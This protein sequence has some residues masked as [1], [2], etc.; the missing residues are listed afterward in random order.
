VLPAPAAGLSRISLVV[1]RLG[2]MLRVVLDTN[3]VLS[4]L[5]HPGGVPGQVIIAW[6]EGFA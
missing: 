4:G 3:V 2:I 6:R 5:I 1:S